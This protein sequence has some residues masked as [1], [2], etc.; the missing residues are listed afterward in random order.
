MILMI[1][2]GDVLSV[3]QILAVD[4]SCQQGSG[5]RS[6]K[7]FL[8]VL[9]D[10]AMLVQHKTWAVFVLSSVVR[11]LAANYIFI[12]TIDQSQV[13]NYKQGQD[14]AVSGHLIS[15][16]LNELEDSDPTYRQWLVSVILIIF[17]KSY[18]HLQVICLATCWDNHEE[19]RGTATRD[20]APDKLETLLADSNPEVIWRTGFN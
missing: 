13:R 10:P 6:H 9:Q 14:E 18:F 20:N 16:C 5:I 7:Y 2:L 15:I 3:F 4:Q 11:T 1:I 19:A 12:I 8:T 17:R